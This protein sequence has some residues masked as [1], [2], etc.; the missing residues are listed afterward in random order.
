MILLTGATG[1][2]GF[3]LAK[4]LSSRGFSA[5]AMVRSASAAQKLSHL[6]G[7]EPVIGD[8]DDPASLEIALQGVER[9]F[10]L[11]NSSEHVEAQQLAFVAAAKHAGVQHIVKLSQL[12]ADAASPVRF[13]RYH[14]KVEQSIQDSGMS[15]TFLRAN[16][17][18]QALLAFRDTIVD[19]GKFFAPIGEAKISIVD[20]RDIA[21]IAAE[22]LTSAGHEGRVY[23]IT[24]PEALTHAEIAA[25]IGQ[26][27]GKPVDFIN[28][29][30]EA[31]HQA[32]L[33]LGFPLWQAD[34]IIEDYAHYGRGEAEIVSH[35]VNDVM[36]RGARSFAE[37]LADYAGALKQ[38]A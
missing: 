23:D 34:G 10:L 30:P 7:I 21:D 9:A 1:S 22:A 13:L 31:M 3:E 32:V 4:L 38:A 37:F 16:L 18:M 14:A 24:G 19:Q 5:K 27:I 2:V 20:I 26:L 12:H 35:H 28:V 17:F 15:Y 36:S 6:P 33:N 29:A 25:R 8:F 11:T